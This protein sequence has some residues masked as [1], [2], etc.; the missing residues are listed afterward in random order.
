[1]M[2]KEHGPDR[3]R[4]P[5]AVSPLFRVETCILDAAE[6]VRLA[7]EPF[8]LF[9]AR[10]TPAGLHGG[11]CTFG[12]IQIRTQS[13][14]N[15]A[16]NCSRLQAEDVR[17]RSAGA[18]QPILSRARFTASPRSFQAFSTPLLRSFQASPLASSNSSSFRRASACWSC[19][20]S[21]C[22]EY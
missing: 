19:R 10:D 7:T 22:S 9:R 1:M 15:P 20:L 8:Q 4:V 3:P 18:T 12:P 14:K 16:P 13:A 2:K 11:G 6:Q 21:I 17:R 5:L